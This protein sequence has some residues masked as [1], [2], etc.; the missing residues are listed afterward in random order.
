MNISFRWIIV[1]IAVFIATPATAESPSNLKEIVEKTV[2]SNPE[3]QAS[4]HNYLA[5]LQEQKAAKGG[6]FPHL[7][8]V[9]TFRSEEQL[10]PKYWKHRYT[11]QTNPV[12]IASNVV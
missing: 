2:T 7:D 1:L 12:G 4:F 10:T 9:S 6:F 8:L 11:R 3:V 5:A